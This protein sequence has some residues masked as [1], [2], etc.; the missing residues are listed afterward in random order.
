M[1]ETKILIVDDEPK[2]VKAVSYRLES[3]GY[4]VSTAYDGEEALRKA[5]VERPDLIVLDLMLPRMDGY[6]VCRKVR[7]TMDTPI[8]ILSARSDELDKV[9]GFQAGVDDYM[10]KPFSPAELALRVKAVLRRTKER[11]EAERA[12]ESISH[13]DLIIDRRTRTVKR[14][15]KG[16]DVTAKEFDLLWLL[17]VNPSKVFTRDEILEKIWSSDYEADYKNV[18]VLVSRLRDK[19]EPD[20]ANPRYIRTVWGVGYKFE[21]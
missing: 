13:G 3:E 14:A 16:V 4:H 7:K 17:A 1:A 5:T 12:N 9:A 6:E 21:P 20:P 10:T 19:L 18:T 11:Q 15:E 2:I 8:I